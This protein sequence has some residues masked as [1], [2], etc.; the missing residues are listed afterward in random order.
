MHSLFQYNWQ[1]RDEWLTWCEDLP[2]A[3]LLL[4]RTGGVKGILATFV[5]IIDVEYSW[6]AALSGRN[7]DEFTVFEYNSLNKVKALTESVK[8]EV[9]EKV[10]AELAKDLHEKIKVAFRIYE[11]LFCNGLSSIIRWVVRII[12][13]KWIW[14]HIGRKM[15]IWVDNSWI[16]RTETCSW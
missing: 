12:M 8:Q 6:L 13:V 14:M 11:M 7:A 10:T 9:D 15:L 16:T 1:V 5:H 2:E 4:E 3:E